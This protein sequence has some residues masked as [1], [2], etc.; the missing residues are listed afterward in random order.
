M[1]AL[2][3]A[4]DAPASQVA[5]G[6]ASSWMER[7]LGRISR[8]DPATYIMEHPRDATLTGLFCSLPELERSCLPWRCGDYAIATLSL[9]PEKCRVGLRKKL[10]ASV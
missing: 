5:P 3:V 4:H 1:A 7:P 9:G 2:L 10:A 8:V 6:L